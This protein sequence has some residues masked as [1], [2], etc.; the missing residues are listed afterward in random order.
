MYK[1]IK[2][3]RSLDFSPCRM[4]QY[5]DDFSAYPIGPACLGVVPAHDDL[6]ERIIQTLGPFNRAWVEAK[7]LESEDP[8]KAAKLRNEATAAFLEAWKQNPN[9]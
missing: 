8:E 7:Q 1:L 6:I 3:S 4:A 5:P 2:N 9:A